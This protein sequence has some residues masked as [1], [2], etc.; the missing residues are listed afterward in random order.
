MFD[1]VLNTPLSLGNYS[2]PLEILSVSASTFMAIWVKVFKNGPSKT[3]ERQ[4]LKV[5][6]KTV[7][8]CRPYISNFFKR[9]IPWIL[10]GPFLNTFTCMIILLLGKDLK[11]EA[12][13][14]REI[15]LME[16][17]TPPMLVSAQACVAKSM[18]ENW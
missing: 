9:C 5:W 13:I 1:R 12:D 7:Y 4:P 2:K 3:C 18:E 8:L 14:I 11:C 17:V 10:L 15:P 6:S 16:K